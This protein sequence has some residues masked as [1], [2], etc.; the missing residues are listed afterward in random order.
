MQILNEFVHDATQLY[1]SCQVLKEVIAAEEKGLTVEQMKRVIRQHMAKKSELGREALPSTAT[2]EYFTL[3]QKVA[4][5]GLPLKDAVSEMRQ[6]SRRH[7]SGNHDLIRFLSQA[8]DIQ[9]RV[10]LNAGRK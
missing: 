9:Q 8:A 5:S 6:W 1:V 7:L 4:W 3:T 2:E 10:L